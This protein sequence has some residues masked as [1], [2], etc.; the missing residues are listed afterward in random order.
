MNMCL[1]VIVDY[2]V[3]LFFLC[4]LSTYIVGFFVRKKK[5]K[6]K[7]YSLFFVFSFILYTSFILYDF[8]SALSSFIS[9]FFLFCHWHYIHFFLVGSI[10]VVVVVFCCHLFNPFVIL[11][12]FD[13][14]FCLFIFYRIIII[15]QA[16]KKKVKKTSL[17]KEHIFPV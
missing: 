9:A 3:S 8:F 11:L 16:V 10:L 14:I 2:S 6:K 1:L 5:R 7:F 12:I 15:I 13:Y 4:N 17:V